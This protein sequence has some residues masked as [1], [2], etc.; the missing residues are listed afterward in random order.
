MNSSARTRSRAR[1]A[2]WYMSSRSASICRGA[3][4]RWTLT[5]TRRPFG[6]TARC[7]CPI[8]AAA[9]GVSSNSR[10]S[11][12]SVRPNSDSTTSRAWS[13]GNGLTESWRP[14]SSK[15][16]SGGTMSGRVERSWPNLTNVGPSSSS[17]SRRRWPRGDRP[18]SASTSRPRRERTAPGPRV[19]N[20]YPK[21][22]L[23]ATW[24]ISEIRPSC[25]TAGLALTLTSPFRPGAGGA[26]AG[27]A[28]ARAPRTRGAS[29]ARP[30]GRARR[31]WS[32]RARPR[33][34][35]PRASGP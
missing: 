23:A 31:A 6:S 10:K 22:C 9:I 33:G 7:T 32:R 16:T 1:R 21:P 26:R 13:K 12:S 18:P 17:I 3:F 5:T 25:R 20:R 29:R 27:R 8:D 11:C 14:F 4:G 24:A 2:S 19:S 30:R 35:L 34:A 15:T 28:G